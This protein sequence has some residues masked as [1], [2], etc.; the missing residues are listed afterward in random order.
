MHLTKH[1]T[2]F[3]DR[4]T[5]VVQLI[6]QSSRRKINP[7]SD[8]GVNPGKGHPLPSRADPNIG[9]IIVLDDLLDHAIKAGQVKC[10]Q[11]VFGDTGQQLVGGLCP[12]LKLGSH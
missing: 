10:N 8:I 3:L 12:P 11:C 9:H 5:G 7:C 2:R 4:R 1:R 6:G